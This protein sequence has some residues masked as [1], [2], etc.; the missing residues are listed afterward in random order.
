MVGLGV[1]LTRGGK[2]MRRNTFAKPRIAVNVYGCWEPN[3]SSLQAR[4]C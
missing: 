2:E 3:L 4:T 1:C